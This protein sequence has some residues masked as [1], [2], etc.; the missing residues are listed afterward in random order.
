VGE[1]HSSHID[2][3]DDDDDDVLLMPKDS[4]PSAVPEEFFC[5]IDH[6]PGEYD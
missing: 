5:P 3:D 4:V 1:G 6:K 2:D